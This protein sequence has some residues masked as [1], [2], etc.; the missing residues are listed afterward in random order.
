MP[1][2]AVYLW[3]RIPWTP[4]GEVPNTYVVPPDIAIEIVSPAQ[5]RAELI[6]KCQ[7]YVAHGVSLALLV[8]PDRRRWTW[9]APGSRLPSSAAPT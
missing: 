4:D 8:D 2:V 9:S 7:W 6:R 1:D 3:E 5:S